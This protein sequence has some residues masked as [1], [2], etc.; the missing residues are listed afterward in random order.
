LSIGRSDALRTPHKTLGV[1]HGGQ[2]AEIGV[3]RGDFSDFLI[4]ELNPGRF[5]AIDLFE[6]EKHPVV[7]GQ[8][9]EVMLE[10]KTH[11]D[12]Y[13]DRLAYFGERMTVIRGPSVEMMTTLPARAFD[14]IYIDANHEYE[15]VAQE[16]AIAVEKIKYDGI[17]VFNDY[18][19][20]D[21]FLKIEYGV[22][23][24]VNEI[25]DSGEWNVIAFALDRHMFCDI[26]IRRKAAAAES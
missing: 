17:L 1:P 25:V 12:F 15:Q 20:F 7:C 2:I 16:G 6:L 21:P 9:Q 14:M 4:E 8:P 19:I 22:V 18:V 3:A 24:A 11:Y 5:Y 13:K 10:G 26:A 23:Q